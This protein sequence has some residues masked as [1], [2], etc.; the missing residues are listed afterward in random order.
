MRIVPKAI[1]RVF[2]IIAGLSLLLPTLVIAADEKG[3]RPCA[4]DIE[5]F[6]KDVKPGAGSIE[7]CLKEHQNDLSASC[8]ER[9]DAA[10][11]RAAAAKEAC[12]EDVAKFCND[13]KPGGGGIMRCL[14][15][16]SADLSVKCKEAL[17]P[18]K[19]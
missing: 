3:T 15:E 7:A 14:R 2:I 1:V 8:K 18:G 12:S 9:M 16:H 6:C 11:K 19:K 10:Q 4:D 17:R 5:K 13:A